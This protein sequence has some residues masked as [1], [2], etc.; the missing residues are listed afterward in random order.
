MEPDPNQTSSPLPSATHRCARTHLHSKRLLLF[1]EFELTDFPAPR[2]LT[3]AEAEALVATEDADLV[4]AGFVE[5]DGPQRYSAC[6]IRD[7]A[8]CFGV[9]KAAPWPDEQALIQP[10]GYA[11]QVLPLSI[12]NTLILICADARRYVDDIAF[13]RS[14][15]GRVDNALLVSAW[16]HGYD[17]AEDAMRRLADDLGLKAALIIDRFHGLCVGGGR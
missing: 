3:R 12:G 1:P 5:A 2:P 7:G 15:E 14:L 17:W 4:I 10:S 16:L 11:P 9:R 8:R 13:R 6:I